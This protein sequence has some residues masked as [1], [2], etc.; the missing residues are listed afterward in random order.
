MSAWG[1]V[2][3]TTCET[4]PAATGSRSLVANVGHSRITLPD[5][6][7]FPRL[8]QNAHPDGRI[9]ALDEWPVPLRGLGAARRR[10]LG[11]EEDL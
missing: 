9:G 6:V 11:P 2:G 1:A 3:R 5:D 4:D 10:N 8:A 7:T